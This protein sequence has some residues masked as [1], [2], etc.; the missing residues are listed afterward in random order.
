MGNVKMLAS[1]GMTWCGTVASHCSM[2]DQVV[3]VEGTVE[4]VVPPVV[5]L[6]ARMMHQEETAEVVVPPVVDLVGRMTNQKVAVEDTVEFCH[7][8]LSV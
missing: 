4:L 5:D 6:V 7:H 8:C 3:A 1:L 2:M